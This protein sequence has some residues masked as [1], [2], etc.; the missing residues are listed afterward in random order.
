M[1]IRI[2][3]EQVRQIIREELL[4]EGAKRGCFCP[5]SPA[6]IDMLELVKILDQRYVTKST[7]DRRAAVDTRAENPAFRM[8]QEGRLKMS[9]FSSF[10]KDQMIF[11]NWRKHINEEKQILE[12]GIKLAKPFLP[13]PLGSGALTKTLAKFEQ[14]PEQSKQAVDEIV[15][16]YKAQEKNAIIEVDNILNE[17]LGSRTILWMVRGLLKKGA[18]LRPAIKNNI[19]AAVSHLIS[20]YKVPADNVKAVLAKGQKL[21]ASLGIGGG[22]MLGQIRLAERQLTKPEEKEKERVVKGMKKNKKDFKKR[23]GKDAESVMYATATKRA[24]ENA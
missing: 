7:V 4:N 12:E 21:I 10:E 18:T 5:L 3:K 20:R 9:K 6:D 17:L 1:K 15:A 2:L 24:K 16:F 13:K 8:M 11:E 14:G 23:Y 19:Q 22:E